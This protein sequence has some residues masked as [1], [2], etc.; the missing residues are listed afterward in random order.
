MDILKFD[1]KVL[2]TTADIIEGYCDKQSSV[3]DEYVSKMN[4]LSSEWSDDETFGSLLEEVKSLQSGINDLMEQIRGSYP[5]Y[6]RDKAE[7]IRNRPKF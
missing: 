5:A 3:I 2:D 4:G 7:Y 6:F 1:D